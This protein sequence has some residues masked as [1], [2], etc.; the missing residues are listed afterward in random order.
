MYEQLSSI[1]NHPIAR[2]FDSSNDI[3]GQQQQSER[4]EQIRIDELLSS[5]ADNRH[6][7]EQV[8]NE[9]VAYDVLFEQRP[10]RNNN[11]TR[12]N[13][14]DSEGLRSIFQLPF[15]RIGRLLE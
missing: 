7:E 15:A 8:E 9:I 11:D 12:F 10:T 14:D 3:N 2:S 4:S 5:I 1:Y 13:D 6:E